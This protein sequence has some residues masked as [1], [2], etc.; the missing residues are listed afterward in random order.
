MSKVN[1]GKAL[2]LVALAVST[3]ISTGAFADDQ[4]DDATSV[5]ETIVVTANKSGVSLLKAPASM[6]VITSEDIKLNTSVDVMDA[7]RQTP[8]VTF[9]GRSTGGRQAMSI[10]GMDSDK[11]MFLV[12]GRRTLGSDNVFGHSNFQY[13]WLPMSAIDSIEVV[14]GPL[15]ALYG[16]DALGGVV[17]VRTKPIPEEWSG[18]V[19]ARSG[20][21]EG[22][23]GDELNGGVHLA[24][25]LTDKL[26]MLLSYT[27]SQADEVMSASEPTVSELEE[28]ESQNIFGR[29]SYL[30]SEDHRLNI[31][32]GKTDEERFFNTS[33]YLSNYDINKQM[34]SVGY[35][36]QF[37]SFDLNLGAY[38]AEME[39]VN[40]R[41][42]GSTP[43][44]PQTLKNSTVDGSIGFEMGSQHQ[45]LVGTEIRQ[46]TLIHPDIDGGEKE[47]LYLAAFAQDEWM[48]TDNLTATVGLR[49]DD[50][51]N[52]GSEISPRAY[53]VYTINDN[54]LMKGGYSHGF[55][56][57]TVK[58]SS[59][60]YRFTS[61][62]M[63]YEYMGNEDVTPETS[64]NYEL[65]L[66]YSGDRTTVAV[67]A[68]Y[69]QIDD[70]IESVCVSNCKTGSDYDSDSPQVKTY[71][72]VEQAMTRGIETE[73]HF[74][75]TE[76][77]AFNVSHAYLDTENKTTGE[78][79]EQ[80]PDHTV[81]SNLTWSDMD[82]GLSMRLRAEYLGEQLNSDVIMPSYTQYHAH[83]VWDATETVSI[84]FGIKNITDVDLSE[85]SEEFD[86]AERGR[87]Y[88]IGVDAHF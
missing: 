30:P 7:V 28:K 41:T 38:H 72:N 14:R 49:W 5:M 54:W 55:R 53:L 83:G 45:M 87:T 81:N 62:S 73:I 61:S 39:Q 51:E 64:E 88:Y 60:E 82:S 20:F 36:G 84:S 33:T 24:G 75:I 21:A 42:N 50:H 15:S 80:R 68:Y 46:E 71:E 48:M 19:S 4:H 57:P 6:S 52:F 27:Y 16:S 17:N 31:D 37:D 79:L 63:S 3:S 10:R 74:D 22:D 11:T 25:P 2:S 44:N 67:T 34:F 47:I 77:W 86:Y 43:S 70:L 59:P 78:E 69:N 8:G 66:T 29:L 40:K 9:Q 58:Q 23:G 13:N 1:K 76:Q 12:D 85:E 65:N 56:A 32:F 35:E 18:S 26:G